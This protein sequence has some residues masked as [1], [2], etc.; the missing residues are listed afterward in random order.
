MRKGSR[1]EDFQRHIDF[2]Y[3]NAL[4]LAF[5]PCQTTWQLPIDWKV[6]WAAARLLHASEARSGKEAQ[7]QS[8]PPNFTG[9]SCMTLQIDLWHAVGLLMTILGAFFGMAKSLLGQS[10]KHIDTQFSSISAT[11]K[12]QDDTSRR[13]E[14]ELLELK[15]ELPRDYVRREDHTRV[16]ASLQLSIDNLRLTVERAMQQVA[17]HRGM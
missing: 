8:L 1:H 4:V 5:G 14:R 9:S 2:S 13:V 10:Q 12:T 11:L 3:R 6:D 16:I 17:S 7:I 15:A